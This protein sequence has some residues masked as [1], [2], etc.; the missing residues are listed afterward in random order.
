MRLLIVHQRWIISQNFWSIMFGILYI[1]WSHLCPNEA[2]RIIYTG[3]CSCSNAQKLLKMVNGICANKSVVLIANKCFYKKSPS[4]YNAFFLPLG[5]LDDISKRQ[6][7]VIYKKKCTLKKKLQSARTA[8]NF[9]QINCLLSDLP[10]KTEQKNKASHTFCA[11]KWYDNISQK[12]E[13]CIICIM[14]RL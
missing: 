5:I 1:K 7:A 11:N 4:N 14:I 9:L 12:T 8:K 10:D 3:L 6:S 13:N 2:N